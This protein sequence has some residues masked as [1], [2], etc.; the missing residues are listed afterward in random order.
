MYPFKLNQEQ[1]D[2]AV[3]L[4]NTGNKL[5]AVKYL[6]NLVKPNWT[7]ENKSCLQW[8]KAFIEDTIKLQECSSDTKVVLAELFKDIQIWMDFE[9]KS[10]NMA[11]IQTLFIRH[12]AKLEDIFVKSQC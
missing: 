5:I 9:S 11:H 10:V 7:E 1:V 4:F 2:I 8:C 3:K 12:G 6:F